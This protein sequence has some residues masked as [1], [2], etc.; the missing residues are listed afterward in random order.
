V[1]DVNTGMAPG[2]GI[3]QLVVGMM[4]NGLNISATLEA[5]ETNNKAMLLSSPKIAVGDN[6]SA[7]IDTTRST[8]YTQTTIQ[9]Q[10]N[11]QSPLVTTSYIKVDLPISLVVGAK[12]TDDNKIIMNVNVTVTK[13]L[14]VATGAAPPDTT[15]QSAITQIM[16]SNND[17][18]VIGG[19]ITENNSMQEDKVPFLGDLPL[20]GNL[21]KGTKEQKQK[22]EL[23]VFLTP[24]IVEE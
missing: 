17:T 2:T 22:V 24:V 5:L 13:I 14:G 6:Q 11:N 12:I 7:K 15:T 9:E 10:P 20:I 21:L 1:G 19:L 8:Y 4:Q 16:A 18:A 23:V 3:G